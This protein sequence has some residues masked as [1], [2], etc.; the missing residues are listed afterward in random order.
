[1]C[2]IQRKADS[3]FDEDVDFYGNTNSKL[4]TLSDLVVAPVI[5]IVD[6]ALMVMGSIT[7]RKI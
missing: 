2:G 6:F 4:L 3:S 7:N 1:M 5:A